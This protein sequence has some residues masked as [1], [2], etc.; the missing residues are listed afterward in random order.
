MKLTR[1]DFTVRTGLSGMTGTNVEE[2]LVEI[3]A[4][5]VEV[6]ACAKLVDKESK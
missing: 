4:A 6:D 3:E 2:T 1:H 5:Q